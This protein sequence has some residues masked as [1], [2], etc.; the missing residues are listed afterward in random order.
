MTDKIELNV[1]NHSL[2]KNGK[3]QRLAPKEWGVLKVLDDKNGVLVTRDELSKEVWDHNVD[4]TTSNDSIDQCIKNIR[5]ALGQP[6]KGQ[7]YTSP[8]NPKLVHWIETVPKE[9]YIFWKPI[10][11]HTHRSIEPPE[12]VKFV[13]RCRDIVDYVELLEDVFTKDNRRQ[14]IT[15]YGRGGVGK[16][17]LAHEV[18]KRLKEKHGYKYIWTCARERKYHFGI[19]HQ[20]IIRKIKSDEPA[21]LPELIIAAAND[22]GLVCDLLEPIK[23]RCLIVLDDFDSIEPDHQPHCLGE[24]YL[25]YAASRI[26]RTNLAESQD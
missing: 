15:L 26:P 16:S 23:Q 3:E 21:L 2:R 24:N 17:R 25:T 4:P 1:Q 11:Y 12:G 7:R 20:D 18:G 14:V 13:S 10:V 19:L 5:R 8:P 6:K 9:G 22:P